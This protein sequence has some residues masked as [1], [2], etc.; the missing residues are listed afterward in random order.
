MDLF[1]RCFNTSCFFV[2]FPM[3]EFWRSSWNTEYSNIVYF[4]CCCF[5][6]LIFEAHAHSQSQLA[7]TPHIHH[8]F[9]TNTCLYKFCYIGT[10]I[11]RPRKKAA[12]TFKNYVLLGFSS[13]H[14]TARTIML[15]IMAIAKKSLRPI[16]PINCFNSSL[17]LF[18]L[19]FCWDFFFFLEFLFEITVKN[20]LSSHIWA[21][22]TVNFHNLK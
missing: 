20:A 16:T 5:D 2:S 4:F 1:V 15:T 13:S 12:W 18:I 7:Q 17:F 10:Q 8:I 19:F 3:N 9:A 6:W 21:Q 14:V 22:L 11:M